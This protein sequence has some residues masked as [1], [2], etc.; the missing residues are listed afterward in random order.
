M[1]K[2]SSSSR[3]EDERLWN[4]PDTTAGVLPFQWVGNMAHVHGGSV[5]VCQIAKE[6]QI[7]HTYLSK[8]KKV[9]KGHITMTTREEY[10]IRHLKEESNVVC[11]RS[12]IR[13]GV[14]R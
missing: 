6:E 11:T 2:F 13:I 12:L 3:V 7:L 10:N 9:G 1:C 4:S 5:V 8:K 14:Y